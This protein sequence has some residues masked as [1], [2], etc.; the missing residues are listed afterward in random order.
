MPDWARFPVIWPHL[1][2]LVEQG[3]Q[4]GR[5]IWPDLATLVTGPTKW[6]GRNHRYGETK[7]S[8]PLTLLPS[9]PDVGE[10]RP[11]AG[12]CEAAADQGGLQ[13]RAEHRVPGGGLQHAQHRRQGQV[14]WP[15]QLP[16]QGVR[17]REEEREGGREEERKGGR[18]EGW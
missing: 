9:A 1:A 17:V 18:W 7:E 8:W 16:C 10:L 12:G 14:P 4:I 13:H 2:T 3:C 5:E 6:S 11:A 15:R